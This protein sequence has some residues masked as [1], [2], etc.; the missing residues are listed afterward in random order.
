MKKSLRLAGVAFAIF[1]LAFA[2]CN[3]KEPTTPTP[4]V[5]A[6]GTV[7]FTISNEVDNAA[8]AMNGQRYNNGAG[9]NYSIHLLKYY[10][11]DFTLVRVDGTEDVRHNVQLID[12]SL[13]E[14]AKFSL[15][16]VLNGN[17][18]ELRF[19]LGVDLYAQPHRRAGRRI[20]PGKRHDLELEH[21]LHF[22]QTR[23]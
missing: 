5:A 7:N 11:C 8:V 18:T 20:R 9:N 4:P 23:R 13:P 2:S 17:Y 10:L 16:S 12:A 22:L 3:K 19:T 21:R 15:D 6:T 14:S 1:T